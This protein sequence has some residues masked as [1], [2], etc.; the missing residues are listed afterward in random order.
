MAVKVGREQ[1]DAIHAEVMGVLTGTGDV[2]LELERGDYEAARRLRRRFEDAM[3]LLDDLG[4][5]PDAAGEEFELS[6][7]AR[8]LAR[9]VRLLGANAAA[10]LQSQIVEP[11]EQGESTLR[12][13]AAQ[14]ACGD[15]LA[16]LAAADANGEDDARDGGA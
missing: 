11:I 5:E 9:A 4:W 12:A 15:V 7:P 6:M 3:R 8:D 2:Y 13:I 10:T 14:T 16:Q 1:R